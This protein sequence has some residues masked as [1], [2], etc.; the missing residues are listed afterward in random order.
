MEAFRNRLIKR[1]KHLKKWARRNDV[2]CFRVYDQD[3][4]EFP[5][6]VEWYSGKVVVWIYSQKVALNYES[7]IAVLKDVFELDGGYLY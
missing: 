6:V 2:A 4:T 1:L 3:L 7:I 5:L